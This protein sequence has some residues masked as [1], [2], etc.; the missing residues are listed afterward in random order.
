MKKTKIL[1][2]S[3][4]V[5]TDILDY[6]TLNPPLGLAYLAAFLEKEGYSVMILDALALGIDRAVRKNKNLLKV[7]ISSREITKTIRNFNPQVVG[8]S[9]AYTAHAADSHEVAGLVKNINP[10]ITV[11][12][13]GAH[14]TAC[15][16]LVLKD[17]NVDAVI[18]G[19]GEMVL[20][21][22]VN[23]IEENKNYDRIQ[24]IALRR[25]NKIIQNPR[26]EYISDIDSLPSPAWHLLPMHIYLKRGKETR[27]FSM[28][29]PR[30]NIITSRGCPGNCVFC[31]I[32]AIWGHQWRPRDPEKVVAE[33]E[34]L[35]KT[36]KVKEFYFLDDNLSFNSER[37]LKICSLII[38]KKLR[39]AWSAPNGI[40]FWTINKK[41]IKKMKDSGLYRIIF[42]FESACQ[43]T[44]R[45]IRKPESFKKAAGIIK[46][47]K[48]IGLWTGS[49]F[50]IGFP[51]ETKEEIETTINWA[52]HSTLDYALFFIATPY[53]GTDLYQEFV[54]RDLFKA[55]E[56]EKMNY[57]SVHFS[58]YD[59]LFLKK[60]E[61]NQLRNKAYSLF[62]ISRIKR[63]LNPFYSLPDFF[64]KVNNFDDLKFFLKLLRSALQMKI[65]SFFNG[66]YKLH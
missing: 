16:S 66:K 40:A 48:K 18:L 19:E 34:H 37:L 31:S 46:Y 50:I 27:E 3:P 39:I 53:P 4:P 38:K 23:R 35:I 44:L 33:M 8:I 1:L 22:L 43:K 10:K 52:V 59:T 26:R 55:K 47:A 15:P 42:G 24:S 17:K 9:C 45:F 29:S 28:R 25:D 61:L 30:I 6:P 2:I 32:H 12:F 7:G 20:M 41:M 51:D 13:G 65:E 63:Y 36:Y 14:A 64:R 21:E 60:E 56:M 62:L 49:T 54:K 5:T 58:G 57:N 11:I